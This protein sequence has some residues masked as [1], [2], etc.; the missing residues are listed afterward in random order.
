MTQIRID[1]ADNRRG[2][3]SKSFDDG[4]AQPELAATVQ[5]RNAVPGR[6]FVSNRTGAIRRVV[7]DDDELAVE[8]FS[9]IGGKDLP[10]EVRKPIAFVVRRDDDREGGRRL[11]GDGR[12]WNSQ[13]L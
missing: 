4:R 10:Y 7:V 2:R 3:G 1:D 9:G 12:G 11:G 6:E 5:H 8:P 13:A